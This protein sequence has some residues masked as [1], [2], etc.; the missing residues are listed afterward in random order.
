MTSY[1]TDKIFYN[2]YKHT[3]CDFYIRQRRSFGD[4]TIY[5]CGFC[6]NLNW[7]LFLKLGQLPDT[8]NYF[9]TDCIS[10]N[11]FPEHK[12]S[13]TITSGFLNKLK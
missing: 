2:N 12:S 13:S 11:I 9:V 3:M 6:I 4:F 1:K 5:I 7:P 10:W 8:E